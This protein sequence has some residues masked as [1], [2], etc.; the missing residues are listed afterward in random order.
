GAIKVIGG[1]TLSSSVLDGVK[2]NPEVGALLPLA[3]LMAVSEDTTVADTGRG[4]RVLTGTDE[5]PS[6]AQ[7]AGAPK[8]HAEKRISALDFSER[9]TIQYLS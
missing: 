7:E 4:M 9:I 3:S 8:S 2:L 1:A 6:S 5:L